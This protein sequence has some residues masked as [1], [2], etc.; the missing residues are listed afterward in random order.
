MPNHLT[1]EPPAPLAADLR[2]HWQLAPG[3][4]F[5]NHG[6][7]GATPKVISNTA[8]DWRRRIEAEPIELLGRRLPALLDEAKSRIGA[9]LGADPANLGFVTNATEGVNAVLRSLRLKPGDELLTTNHV[10]N[11][12]RQSMKF[13]ATQVGGTVREI[14]LPLPIMSSQA[15]AERVIGAFSTQTRLLVIDHVTSPTAL[16]FPVEAIARACAAR[17]IEL[18]VDGAHAP[19]MVPLD[20]RA[21]GD[22]GVTFYAGNLHKWC[23]ASKGTAFLWARPDRAKTV[24][25]LVISH[26]YGQGMSEEFGWQGTRDYA[27]WLSAGAAIDFLGSFDWNAVRAHN[28]AVATWAHQMLCARLQVEPISPLDGVLLGSMATVR[29]PPPLNA[30]DAPGLCALQQSLYDEQKIEVPLFTW[31]EQAFLRVSCQIYNTPEDYERLAVEIARR[32]GV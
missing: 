27:G 28:H 32:A 23:C 30:L 19:G 13:A 3:V 9:F 17:G 6:S 20:L 26:N 8:D 25:P 15:I 29:L 22:A 4:T 31:S 7:F 21:L 10:Y 14:E 1:A 18:L 16:V 24:H 12:V 5:L 11:A 2:D